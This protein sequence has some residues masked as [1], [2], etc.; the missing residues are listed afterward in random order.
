[1]MIRLCIL[2][3][4]EIEGSVLD[5][6]RFLSQP[7]RL[8]LL[9]YLAL[10]RGDGWTS[11]DELLAMFWPELDEAH[12]RA[13]LR[14]ALNYLRSALGPES[15]ESRGH[16]AVR[17]VPAHLESDAAEFLALLERGEHAAAMGRY[18]GDL[19]P[20]LEVRG[21]NEF[22]HWLSVERR[23]FRD[24]ATEA[25][26]HLAEEARDEDN[27]EEAIHWAVLSVDLT[28]LSDRA[29]RRLMGI[30]SWAGNRAAALERYGVFEQELRTQH[31]AVP[32]KATRELAERIRGAGQGT[33]TP[34]AGATAT[35][36]PETTTAKAPGGSWVRTYRVRLPAMA[37]TVSAALLVLLT[38]GKGG[39]ENGS[40]LLIA[41]EQSGARIAVLPFRVAGADVSL[42]YLSEGLPD[43]LVTMFPGNPGPEAISVR[44]VL[45]AVRRLQGNTSP[46]AREQLH[47]IAADLDVRWLLVGSLVGDQNRI[48]LTGELWDREGKTLG[49][50]AQA[51]GRTDSLYILTERLA[52]DI[53]YQMSGRQLPVVSPGLDVRL[54]TLRAF[55]KGEQAYRLGRYEVADSAFSEAFYSPTPFPPAAVGL[56]KTRLAAPWIRGHAHVSAVPLALQVQD[57]LTPPDRGF[58]YAVAGPRFPVLSSFEEHVSAWRQ[59]VQQWPDR[60]EN[61]FQWG[62]ALFHVGR[63]V[64][65]ANS[66]QLAWEAFEQ[67]LRL[68]STYLRPV[69]HMIEIAADSGRHADLRR[70]LSLYEARA[71]QS[72]QLEFLRWRA[73]L[74][75]QDDEALAE[76]R[77]SFHTLSL[78]STLS[79]LRTA[80]NLGI[81]LQD[82]HVL[83][84]LGGDRWHEHS[85][86]YAF[87]FR[88]HAL[89]LN[90]GRL[91][92]AS[93]LA[94]QLGSAA[95]SDEVGLH[96]AIAGAL[97]TGDET[98]AA[99][100]A[101]RLEQRLPGLGSR[102]ETATRMGESLCVVGLWA[103]LSGD[104]GRTDAVLHALVDQAQGR[105]DHAV[106][107]PEEWCRV[108]LEAIRAHSVND[109]E[110]SNKL[111]D[112]RALVLEGVLPSAT[113]LY[114]LDLIVLAR[115]FSDLGQW[116]DA[117]DILQR[118]RDATLGLA[119]WLQQEA[120]VAT[121]L[122]Y[123]DE[124]RAAAEHLRR[125]NGSYPA[126]SLLRE[127]GPG[128]E[129]SLEHL[130]R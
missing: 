28:P 129:R 52:S 60:P 105:S 111:A 40:G 39:S 95:V 13:A 19:L 101:L 12:A 32:S 3:R 93:R 4:L 66:Q 41:K 55:L 84:E 89:A 70:L 94:E 126:N 21:L 87:L 72:D 63:A 37:L 50:R 86:R 118:R 92:E 24:L 68:D 54:S 106:Y 119:Q 17:A 113:A 78:A 130:S 115:I 69:P 36:E 127:S 109:P 80:Q 59:A 82:A 34:S 27:T 2:G 16:H 9:A 23:R 49:V 26:G 8:A 121:A 1:M 79:I 71:P 102:S 42:G 53:L 97:L 29:V 20:G 65:I 123:T 88:A 14:Q 76:V 22:E 46:L 33:A 81:G 120:R 11:R 73:A 62:D 43:L 6:S 91:Q 47:N 110:T 30:Q 124:A 103:A 122:G 108:A 107:S 35:E 45:Y 114:G 99:S 31:D 128:T 25:A 100:A 38:L 104:I 90:S 64:G 5:P 83:A 58:V 117:W 125:L 15:I 96:F 98:A 112:W 67:A 75:L 44:T 57:H 77:R 56:V 7:K 85:A 48:V 18:G 10:V 61:W 74:A 116:Q 51:H